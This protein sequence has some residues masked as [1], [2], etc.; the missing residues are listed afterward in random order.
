MNEGKRRFDAI[1]DEY[2]FFNS[3][4]AIDDPEVMTT[5]YATLELRNQNLFYQTYIERTRETLMEI[6]DDDASKA[7]LWHYYLIRGTFL[8][9]GLLGVLK[10]GS[11]HLLRSYIESVMYT[12]GNM[13]PEVAGMV[14]AATELGHPEE[15]DFIGPKSQ[16]AQYTELFRKYDPEIAV[17]YLDALSYGIETSVIE[18]AII[19]DIDTDILL[20]VGGK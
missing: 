15:D 6:L 19:N 17:K 8:S 1:H 2:G 3:P 14:Y 12:V 4:Y 5:T 11:D 7:F 20:S 9:V 10:I 13:P 16:A 18:N